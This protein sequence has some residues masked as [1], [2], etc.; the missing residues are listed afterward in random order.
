MALPIIGAAAGVGRVGLA[1][2]LGGL[3]L[4]EHMLSEK[5]YAIVLMHQEH[6]TIK[7]FHL[8]DHLISLPVQLWEV[9]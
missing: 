2:A 9:V 3:V 5:N 6:Q 7:H 4:L 1:S 8:E